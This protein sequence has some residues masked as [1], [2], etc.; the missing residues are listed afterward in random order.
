[1]AQASK[2]GGPSITPEEAADPSPP[3]RPF[4][5]RR[6]ELGKVD[7]EP[8][9]PDEEEVPVSP[10]GR[11][12][13]SSTKDKTSDEQPKA[14]PRKAARTTGNRSRPAEKETDSTVHSTD[15]SGRKTETESAEDLEFDEF[16]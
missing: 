6:P 7:R 15:G 9:R 1:M 12:T 16:E 10:G 14:V 2:H 8:Y 13:Q 5:V 3:S 11:S 4:R